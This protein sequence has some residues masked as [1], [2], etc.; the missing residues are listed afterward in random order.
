[1]KNITTIT[2]KLVS[3]TA[4]VF[5]LF[6]TSCE[7]ESLEAE[8]PVE[9]QNDI[10]FVSLSSEQWNAGS[11]YKFESKLM[12]IDQLK[13]NNSY[14]LKVEYANAGDVKEE[15]SLLSTGGFRIWQDGN[16]VKIGT[17]EEVPNVLSLRLEITCHP[18]DSYK[19]ACRCINE[20]SEIRITL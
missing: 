16:M 12:N 2:S 11:T 5:I 17:N 4:L 15:R 9:Q 14:T 19:D 6:A 7:K 13:H 3:L 1:M 20:E 8:M 10:Q 18:R